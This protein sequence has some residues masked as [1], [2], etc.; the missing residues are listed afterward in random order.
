MLSIIGIVLKK[1]KKSNSN[2]A[3]IVLQ[4]DFDNRV[5]IQVKPN[6]VHKLV[7]VDTGQRVKISY[8]THLSERLNKKTDDWNRITY[9][10][11]E[12]IQVI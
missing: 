3:E 1:D 9:W 5:S 2:K 10:I 4:D 7:E 12:D 6:K 11:L 8:K